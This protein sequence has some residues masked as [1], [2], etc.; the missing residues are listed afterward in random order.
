LPTDGTALIGRD[1]ELSRLRELVSSCADGSQV[2]VLLG[3]AGMGKTILLAEAVREARSAGM[4]VLSVAGQE[5]EQNLAFAGRLRSSPSGPKHEIC[6]RVWLLTRSGKVT[7]KRRHF[8]PS[9]STGAISS[10]TKPG[11]VYR[12]G[13][14]RYVQR[15]SPLKYATCTSSQGASGGW[16]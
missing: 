1:S 8:S 3:D 14:F 4:R 11:W 9:A 5:S 7:L 12:N 6:S 15:A 2:L 16:S 10:V 13:V